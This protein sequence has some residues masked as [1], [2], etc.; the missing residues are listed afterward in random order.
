MNHE[1]A[2]QQAAG[3]TES[4]LTDLVQKEADSQNMNL[5]DLVR[6]Q[7]RCRVVEN[8]CERQ[9]LIPPSRV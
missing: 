6:P 9:R 2:A 3:A 5:I 4:R 8:F 7:W 1:I